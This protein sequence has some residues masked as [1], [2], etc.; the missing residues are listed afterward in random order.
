[1]IQVPI[2]LYS[3]LSNNR[4]GK[5]E[6]DPVTLL[7]HLWNC[8]KCSSSYRFIGVLIQIMLCIE[9]MHIA[10]KKVDFK[11]DRIFLTIVAIIL[12]LLDKWN[13]TLLTSTR[14]WQIYFHTIFNKIYSTYFKIIFG[15]TLTI[16]LNIFILII[17]PV[18]FSVI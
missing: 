15:G 7:D 1:M 5:A 12:I 9:S 11:I 10:I 16:L 8:F 4:L 3:A 6:R 18:Q 17:S 2:Y 14:L 13:E